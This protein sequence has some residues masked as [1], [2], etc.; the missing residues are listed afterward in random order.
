[1]SVR[2]VEIIPGKT[3]V[4]LETPNEKR[5]LVTL[6]ETSNPLIRKSSESSLLARKA[7]SI[8]PTSDSL[9]K[10]FFNDTKSGFFALFS[11]CYNKVR[12]SFTI[13]T[14]INTQFSLFGTHD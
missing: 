3:T 7:A 11:S 4:G 2:I 8:K 6:G 9:S 1:M 5:E 10:Q 14:C 12:A 13:S